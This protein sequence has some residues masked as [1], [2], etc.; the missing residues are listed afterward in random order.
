[1]NLDHMIE[2]FAHLSVVKAVDFFEFPQSVKHLGQAAIA[3]LIGK[4]P[5]MYFDEH[6]A[7]RLHPLMA[8]SHHRP[9]DREMVLERVAWTL[10]RHRRFDALANL[11]HRCKGIQKMSAQRK[12]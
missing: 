5:L 4:S 12:P 7:D 2:R 9:D 6:S 11:L 10:A 3:G 1:M 8:R